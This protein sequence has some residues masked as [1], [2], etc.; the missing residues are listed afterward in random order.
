MVRRVLLVAT[1][2]LSA[3]TWAYAQGRQQP[4]SGGPSTDERLAVLESRITDMNRHVEA[5]KDVAIASVTNL[6]LSGRK[7]V[8]S[9][10]AAA[11]AHI[12][13]VSAV[14][15]AGG[16]VVTG[17]LIL[18]GFFG[19]RTWGEVQEHL[20]T[21]RKSADDINSSERR[22]QDK[23]R[24]EN[25][26]HQIRLLLECQQVDEALK[27][28]EYIMQLSTHADD[29]ERQVVYFNK[30][31]CLK[32]KQRFYEAY[33][34]ARNVTEVLPKLAKAWYNAACYASLAS[35]QDQEYRGPAF[36]CLRRAYELSPSYTATHALGSGYATYDAGIQKELPKKGDTDLDAIRELAEFQE[37]FRKELRLT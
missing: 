11:T 19:F 33:M 4:G 3:T 18:V 8:E 1:I 25:L 27:L 21:I 24:F 29:M 36:A 17:I 9:I 7:H 30:A 37:L 2:L 32:R 13:A 35:T 14:T 23:L 26:K 6:E 28:T 34:N 22:T 12:E 15:K 20:Q 16:A 10:S 31:L 5:L